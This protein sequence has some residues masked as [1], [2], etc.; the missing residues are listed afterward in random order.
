MSRRGNGEGSIGQD[1]RGRWVARVTLANGRRKALYGRTRA[2]VAALM[3]K[4]IRERDQGLPVADGRLTVAAYLAHWL[5]H[6]CRHIRPSTLLSYER[7][8]RLY[9]VPRFGRLRLDA[10]SPRHVEELVAA[11]SAAGKSAG[12]IAHVRATLRRA[13]GQAVRQ[14][15]LPRNVASGALV[16][17]PRA[18]PPQPRV[19]TPEEARAIL[20]AFEGHRLEAAVAVAIGC[21]LRLGEQRALRWADVDLD[22]AR[23]TVRHAWQET[24]DGPRLAEP[25]TRASRAPVAIPASVVATLRRHKAAQ[26]LD[27]LAAGR[28]LD[29][30]TTFVF[31]S[32]AGTAL[33]G[34]NILHG[35][36]AQLA[37]AGLPRMRWHDLRHA[38]ASLLLANGADVVTVA[39][40]LRHASPTTT[41]NTYAHALPGGVEAAAARMDAILTGGRVAGANA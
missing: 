26:A 8:V 7:H 39:A 9:L 37:A 35:F 24:P 2:E 6:G 14:G 41:L 12:T 36:Q 34:P 23:L 18:T 4:T 28:Y 17:V 13:L 1:S 15:I 30:A 21:G 10:L 33:D 38:C 31:T 11:L 27:F 29:P 40:V 19:P 22:A 3:A 32:R 5:E 16:A 20:A 25:K